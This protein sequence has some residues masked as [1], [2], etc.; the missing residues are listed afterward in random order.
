MTERYI[1]LT[2]ALE[3]QIREEDAQAIIN[4]IKM[5]KG[6]GD[7]VP[8]VADPMAYWAKK[9]AQR[10]IEKKLLEALYAKDKA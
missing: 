10:E 9:D 1:A 2:V 3:G 4:A 6:V 8:V 5:I 7:V